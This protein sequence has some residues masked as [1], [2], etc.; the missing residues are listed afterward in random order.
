MRAR[1]LGWQI[2]TD[3]N[4]ELNGQYVSFRDKGS[5]GGIVL[6]WEFGISTAGLGGA[7]LIVYNCTIPG[8]GI[9]FPNGIYVDFSALTED[10][11]SVTMLYQS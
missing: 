3:D 1:L 8:G 11:W 5:S 4:T 9:L 10:S 2:S 7:N 6:K